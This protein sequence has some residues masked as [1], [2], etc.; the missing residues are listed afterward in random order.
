MRKGSL[1]ATIVVSG[2]LALSTTATADVV[3]DWNDIALQ[4]VA[5][6]GAGR[7]GPSGLIDVAMV[8]VA[9][10]DAMQAYQGRFELYGPA[11]P[12]PAGSFVAAVA[13]AAHDV[14]IGVGLTNTASGTVDSRYQAYLAA[15]NLTADAG[16]E[17]GHDAAAGVL[18]ARINNDGRVPPNAPQFFGGTNPG[19]WRPTSFLANGQPMPMV[20]AYL[21][22]LSPFTLKSPT[23][24]RQEPPPHLASGKYADEFDEVKTLGPLT[25]SGRTAN[26]T[27]MALF[28]ADNAVAY[29]NRT[30]RTIAGQYFTDSGDTAHMFALVNMAM[31]ASLIVAWGS[32]QYF[33]FWRPSRP[34]APTQ[35]APAD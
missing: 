33:N 12:N 14:L 1:V 11:I 26:Q 10:H 4:A 30:M 21:A 3:T 7:P 31:N 13:T 2:S 18:D 35:M 8:Q 25:G 20:A 19:D 16:K 23:Q 29:W 15:R 17:V 22:T 5:S 28:F 27:D 32:K 6:A 9:V 24:F 34:F